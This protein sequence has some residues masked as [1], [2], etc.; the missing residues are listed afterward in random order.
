MDTGHLLIRHREGDNLAFHQIV[1][2]L[3]SDV[4]GYIARCGIPHPEQEDIFQDIFV[5]V[6]RAAYQYQPDKPF[7]PWLFGIV[8][9]TVRSYLRY[10]RVKNLF[11]SPSDP[12][13][14]ELSSSQECEYISAQKIFE[15]KETAT[16]FNCA[17]GELP[18]AQREVVL[19]CCIKDMSHGEV[20]QALEIPINTV[21][22][23]L[24]R[25]RIRL[26]SKLSQRNEML[27]RETGS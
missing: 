10:Q 15:A 19:L 5:K 11:A 14:D 4:L 1:E 22:T 9:N 18:I 2:R 23:N 20:A 3:G 13:L 7:K 8:C 24:R 27:R 16:W 26:A 25:A 6:H 17:I 12:K 21:K